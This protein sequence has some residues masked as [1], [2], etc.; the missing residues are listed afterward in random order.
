MIPRVRYFAAVLPA[1]WPAAR[2]GFRLQMPW[3]KKKKKKRKKIVEYT[4]Y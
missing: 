3:W 2:L 1:I 4:T